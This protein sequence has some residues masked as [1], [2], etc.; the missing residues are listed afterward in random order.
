VEE[1]AHV[2]VLPS[3]SEAS[4]PGLLKKKKIGGRLTYET[5]HDRTGLNVQ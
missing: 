3:R 2:P 1:L 4:C 5:D